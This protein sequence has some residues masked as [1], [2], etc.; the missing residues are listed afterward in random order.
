MMAKKGEQVA[1]AEYFADFFDFLGLYEFRD[2]KQ[3]NCGH[4]Y[5]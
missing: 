4:C 2:L 1:S 3:A 5:C